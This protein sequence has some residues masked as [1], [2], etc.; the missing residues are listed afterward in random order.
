MKDVYAPAGPPAHLGVLLVAPLNMCNAVGTIDNGP[1]AALERPLPLLG[2]Q[3]LSR[4]FNTVQHPSTPEILAVL[5]RVEHLSAVTFRT[6]LEGRS[7]RSGG[8][9]LLGVKRSIRVQA[10]TCSRCCGELV[11]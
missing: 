1:V 6:S 10:F 9:E 4:T 3:R 2:L 5:K 11:C 8:R 7:T